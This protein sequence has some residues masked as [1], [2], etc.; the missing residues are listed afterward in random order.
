MDYILDF[1]DETV[2][3]HVYPESIPVD[4]P[5]RQL[6]SLFAFTTIGGAFAYLVPATILY[7]TVFDRRLEKHEKYIPNQRW[8]EIRYAMWALPYMTFPTALMFLGE[9]RGYSMLYDNI[10]DHPWG[11]SFLFITILFFLTFT[12]FWIYWIHRWLHHPILYGFHKPHHRW[13]ICTPYASHAFHPLD[14]FSQSF[15]YHMYVFLFPMHKWL[16]LGLFTFVNTWSTMIHDEYYVVPEILR[17]IINGSA[18]HTD[19]HLFFNYNYGQ[20]FTFWDRVF[21]SFKNPTGFIPGQSVYDDL[22]R[23]GI[24][25]ERCSP[26]IAAELRSGKSKSQ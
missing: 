5:W 20:Y 1:L 12:D 16:Y 23:K 21:G 22:A 3:N 14:G 18:H 6:A 17:P 15:P 8:L 7:Y 10:D 9:V 25:T 4:N 2:F 26:S 13:L 11:V 19:H 24:M